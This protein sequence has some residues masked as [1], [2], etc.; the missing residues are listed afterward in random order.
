MAK[1]EDFIWGA[2]SAAYQV[3]GGWQADRR[4]LSKWDVYTNRDRVTEAVTGKQ[5]TGN[6]AINQYSREQYLKDIATMRDL[7]I[8]AYRFS[9]S[10]PRILPDGVGRVNQAGVDYYSR[11]VDDLVANGI[12]PVATLYHWDFPWA[13]QEQGGFHNRAVV[14]WF[15]DYAN[16]VF[17]A[18]GDRV[19]KFLTM[20]EPFIDLMLM[21][22]VVDNVRAR[23][24]PFQITDALWA[25]QVPAMHNLF[26]ASAAAIASFRAAGR[27]GDI[28]IAIPL[29]PALPLDAAKAE[30]V[31][32]AATWDA[33]ANRWPLDAAIK[34]I[35]ADDVVAVLRRLVPGFS[36]SDADREL[37][38]AGTID[39][40]GINYYAPSIC[41]ANPDFA[42]GV[43]WMYNP[44]PRPAFNGPDRPEQLKALLLR[45]RDEYGNRPVLITENGAGFGPDDEQMSG[46]TV[47]DPLR[48][49]YIRRH[50][51]AA[52]SARAE[53]ADLRGYME[54]CLFDNFEWI[55]GY[56]GR[57][58]IVHVDFDTQKRTPKQSFAAY[59]DLI[60]ASAVGGLKI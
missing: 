6:V 21:D 56:S 54:W 20:N 12:A 47:R 43:D 15:R 1:S 8:N 44:D 22:C 30:E 40:L 25:K 13:L 19:S 3:E 14:D 42:L 49:D 45:I 36:V 11:L 60:A 5:E 32:A 24:P 41:R 35:Y 59:R 29:F 4:G 39:Y 26:L 16:V 58:G 50:I 37:L 52:L 9:I 55:R 31:A 46:D 48:T 53:G 17:D 27:K 2:A 18:L 51:A 38:A 28:G 33:F 23:R 7:G 34:G 10:W 57:F